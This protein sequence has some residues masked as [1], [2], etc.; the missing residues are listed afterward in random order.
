[1]KLYIHIRNS[2]PIAS[3]S[4]I[5][6]TVN[7]ITLPTILPLCPQK[8]RKK[9]EKAFNPTFLPGSYSSWWIPVFAGSS[10]ISDKRP[11]V[12]RQFC[13]PL[14]NTFPRWSRAGG[15]SCWQRFGLCILSA[16]SHHLRNLSGVPEGMLCPFLFLVIHLL[17][18]EIHCN[19]NSSVLTIQ[20]KRVPNKRNTYLQISPSSNETISWLYMRH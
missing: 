2:K 11:V 4:R 16:C 12:S 9:K 19:C 3:A 5:L 10:N 6:V 1:M 20:L 7:K 18:A 17:Q 8:K 14:S 13:G 15:T